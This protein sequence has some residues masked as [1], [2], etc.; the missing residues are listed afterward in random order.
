MVVMS[1]VVLLL[2]GTWADYPE[3][4]ALG[5]AGVATLLVAAGWMLVRPRLRA[6]R[7][8]SPQR[9]AEG[10]R[11][12]G[13]VTVTNTAGRRSPPVVATETV[14]NDRINVPLPS[15]EAGGSVRMMYALP[16]GRRGRYVI[17]PF[18]VDHTDPLRL[19]RSGGS[20]GGHSI[21]YVHPRV[22]TVVPMSFGGP[23]EMEGPTSSSSP[24]GGVTF[25]SLRDYHPGDNWR[26][27]HWKS[28]ARVGKLL[29]RHNVVPDEPRHLIILDTSDGPYDDAS[30][31]HAVRVAASLCVAADRAGYP[32]TLRRTS[33]WAVAPEPPDSQWDNGATATLDLLSSLERSSQDRGLLTLTDLVRDVASPDSGVALSV[34]TGEVEPEHLELLTTMR[35]C[36]LTVSLIRI[37]EKISRSVTTPAGVLAVNARTSSDFAAQWNLVVPP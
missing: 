4:I 10:A 15:L 14:G 7:E 27:I 9:V 32:V 3:L 13:V 21:L 2:A 1:A 12:Y 25:H 31:E 36:F 5:L 16:T 33:D 29:V 19:L 17:P 18:E 24:Q 22:H 23:R 26:R 30:F 35:S 34:V 6:V 37:G 20:C 8:T 11:A 28:S